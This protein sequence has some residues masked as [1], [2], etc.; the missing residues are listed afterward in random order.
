MWD[1]CEYLPEV[2]AQCSAMAKTTKNV[3]NLGWEL[4]TTTK[5]RK[6][7]L[8]LWYKSRVYPHFD[9]RMHTGLYLARMHLIKLK[10]EQKRAK[11]IIRDTEQLPQDKQLN[12]LGLSSG[13]VK[14]F[15]FFFI[16]QVLVTCP[17]IKIFPYLLQDN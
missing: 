15:F 6:G 13:K 14:L 2:P 8:I 3:R 7:K 16:R 10:E 9:Y 1:Y 17:F 5:N 12:R 4:R 11:R